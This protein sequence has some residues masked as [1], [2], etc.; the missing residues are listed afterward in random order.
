M[1]PQKHQ[2]YFLDLEN[3]YQWNI[4]L[5][6]QLILL[7]CVFSRFGFLVSNCIVH[8]IFVAWLMVS[9]MAGFAKSL[10]LRCSFARLSVRLARKEFLSFLAEFTQ[11]VIHCFL[12][13]RSKECTKVQ[14]EALANTEIEVRREAYEIPSPSHP[15]QQKKE[16]AQVHVSRA[17]QRQCLN[18]KA[19]K[20]IAGD[21]KTFPTL[22]FTNFSGDRTC[23]LN[24]SHKAPTCK[25][26]K[27]GVQPKSTSC[28]SFTKTCKNFPIDA[29]C[30]ATIYLFWSTHASL[31][32][33]RDFRGC[34]ECGKHEC[35]NCCTGE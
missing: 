16:T 25:S 10:F 1:I 28:V 17:V 31:T 11:N 8:V 24:P 20:N 7:H 26:F 21:N 12:E 14:I 13:T 15:H 30:C 35:I 9:T 5:V 23:T 33:W 18:A 32:T 19:Q 29:A 3:F 22:T 4:L 6:E 27:S 2:V 34:L